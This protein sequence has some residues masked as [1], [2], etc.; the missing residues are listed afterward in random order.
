M[1]QFL[2]F[3]HKEF[4]HIFRDRRSVMILLGMPIV[5][6]I[7]FG[8]AITTEVSNAR[9][10]VLDESKDV[11]T[12][13]II[14]QLDASNYFDLTR[15]LKSYDEVEP[16]LKKGNIDLVLLIGPHF[17]R[18]LKHSGKVDLQLMVDGC[19]VNNATLLTNYA[20]QIINSTLH[21]NNLT[22]G[23]I[24][25]QIKLLYNPAMKSAYNFVPGVM[26]IILMLICAM[27]T[28]ISI[29]REK[30]TGTMEVLL[31]S[32]IHPIAIILA[33]AIPYLVLSAMNVI[34]IVL[35]SVFVLQVPVAGSLWLLG[36]LSVLFI[37]VALALGL[38]VSTCVNTQIAAMLIS[39]MMMMIPTVLLSG[40][41]YPIESMPVA[42][43]YFSDIIPAKWFIMA[44]R[45][46]MIEGVG[47]SCIL[48]EVGVLCFMGVVLITASLKKFSIRL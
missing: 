16:L 5:Q 38:F 20:Q 25:P 34:S 23:T 6:I 31:V 32:P 39:G 15:N 26:G 46:V 37:I 28:S 2:A 35:L 19:D 13:R 22:A 12:Q 40:V 17:E 24:T 48:K 33:K 3:V 9:L 18:E 43:Q 8:F 36:S 47:L 45:K 27:M 44:M 11:T 1:K 41:I 14:T 4:Y 21:S 29:V 42:L 30:E 10:A 7:L